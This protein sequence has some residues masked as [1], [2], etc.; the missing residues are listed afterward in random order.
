MNTFDN[1][2]EELDFLKK[3]KLASKT[4]TTLPTFYYYAPGSDI[5]S[6]CEIAGFE[7]A[8][9]NWAIMVIKTND[10][11][12]KIHSGYLLE[13][14][15][16]GTAYGKNA[17]SARNHKTVRKSNQKNSYI[18]LDI[19]TTGFNRNK[20]KII[21]I[22]AIKYTGN[23][24]SEFHEYVNIDSVIPANITLLTGISNDTIRDAGSIDIVM[25]RFLSFIGKYTLVGHNIRLFDIPFLNTVCANLGLP[26]IKNRLL[27]TLPLSKEKLPG[28]ENH[29]LSTICNYYGIDT[30]N[31]HHAL[32]DCYMCDSVY[33]FL[34]SN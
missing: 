7:R 3:Y 27:D 8:Y 34:I 15:D 22:A 21:E 13:M 29:K 19:E 33:R 17:D 14:R 24:V 10:S 23:N 6:V 25:P 18:V 30:S 28:L 12:I 1:L 2:T 11:Y 26:N 9:D 5:P 32:A 20:D 4:K 31:A 16:R